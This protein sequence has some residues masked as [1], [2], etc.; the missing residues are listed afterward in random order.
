[1]L[2]LIYIMWTAPKP[3]IKTGYPNKRDSSFNYGDL[4]A[5]ID[6]AT[7]KVLFY[8][9]RYGKNT[10]DFPSFEEAMLYADLHDINIDTFG[11]DKYG[12][13]MFYDTNAEIGR[14]KTFADGTKRILTGLDN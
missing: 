1:M 4:K 3:I 7:G 9:L 6:Y 10:L 14:M 2:H 5:C 12:I 11:W 13:L 8:S